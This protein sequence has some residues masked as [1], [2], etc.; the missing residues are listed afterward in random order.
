[1]E[2]HP[3]MATLD[4]NENLQANDQDQDTRRE[5]VQEDTKTRKRLQPGSPNVVK[6]L[7][8]CRSRYLEVPTMAKSVVSPQKHK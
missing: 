3:E 7:R 6:I 1:M 2:I 8:F 5:K 4:D